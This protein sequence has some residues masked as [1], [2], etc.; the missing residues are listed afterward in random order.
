MQE[1]QKGK[2]SVFYNHLLVQPGL[3]DFPIFFGSEEL[4][5]LKGSPFLDSIDQANADIKGDYEDICRAIPAFKDNFSLQ[6]YS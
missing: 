4:A 5:L 1:K 2:E 6:D 3:D